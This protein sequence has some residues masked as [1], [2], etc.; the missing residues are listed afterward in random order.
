MVECG[1]LWVELPG[2]TARTV[3]LA[4]DLTSQ[5]LTSLLCKM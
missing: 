1:R 4:S 3:A 2:S 5:S